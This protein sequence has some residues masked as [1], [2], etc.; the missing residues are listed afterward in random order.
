MAALRSRTDSAALREVL[1]EGRDAAQNLG[2][3][4]RAELEV[5]A[6]VLSINPAESMAAIADHRPR[7]GS[8]VAISSKAKWLKAAGRVSAANRTSSLYSEVRNARRFT[9]SRGALVSEKTIDLE[10]CKAPA[11]P[12]RKGSLL[13]EAKAWGSAFAVAAT[14][15]AAAAKAWA[16][17]ATGRAAA[18][19]A[20]ATDEVTAAKVWAAAATGR[21]AEALS[22]GKVPAAPPGSETPDEQTVAP[23]AGDAPVLRSET[24]AGS[25]TGSRKGLRVS[26]RD[27]DDATRDAGSPSPLPPR[28]EMSAKL[29]AKLGGVDSPASSLRSQSSGVPSPGGFLVPPT[30]FSPRRAPP[31][32]A[33]RFLGRWRVAE[34]VGYDSYLKIYNMPWAV[35]KV[36]VRMRPEA[37]WFWDDGA[38]QCT[39]DCPGA[40]TIHKSYEEGESMHEDEN[41]NLVWQVRNRVACGRGGGEGGRG[42]GRSAVLTPLARQLW[43]RLPCV[44]VARQP[45]ARGVR[46]QVDTWWDEDK[47]ITQEFTPCG[48]CNGG[49]PI[50]CTRW[51]DYTDRLVA[52]FDYGGARPH[53][54]YC[55]RK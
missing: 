43:T 44:A 47:L 4:E 22:G 37:T 53:I 21:A 20:A 23:Q 31:E 45:P 52:R 19:A 7:A 42:G 27:P 55:V 25:S 35:R 46:T 49:K 2:F 17:A 54:C 36:A 40:K 10:L 39:I 11:A 28:A 3:V 50:V 9:S 13:Q 1:D 41:F 6:W 26:F 16:A 32:S 8:A 38:L 51:V 24:S 34:Q 48:G 29:M 33:G 18:M 5:A 30:A 15:E 14:D 12:R